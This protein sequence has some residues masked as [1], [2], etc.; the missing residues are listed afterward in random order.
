[1][2]TGSGSDSGTDSESGSPSGSGSESGSPKSGYLF[3]TL[4]VG[5][6]CGQAAGLELLSAGR[7]FS[8]LRSSL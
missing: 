1:M 6:A 5:T 8:C 7:E 3:S 4:Q 2:L